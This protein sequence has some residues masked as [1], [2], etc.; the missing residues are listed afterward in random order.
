MPEIGRSAAQKGASLQ[1]AQLAI[2]QGQPVQCL[3]NP[4]EYTI[5]KS[6]TWSPQ[7]VAGQSLPPVQYGGGAPQELSFEILLDAEYSDHPIQ[8]DINQLLLAMEPDSRLTETVK[9]NSITRPPHVTFSWGATL[10]FTAG[11]KSLSVQFLRFGEEGTEEDG[12]PTRAQ[13]KLT[14]IQVA[15]SDSRS[16]RPLLPGQNPTTRA[17]AEHGSRTVREGDSL[18]SIA[19]EVYGDP[20]AWRA[21]AEAN[22][23]DDPLGLRRGSRLSIPRVRA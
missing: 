21:I 22:G 20:T 13:V 6:S 5:T 10:A 2:E 9:G 19:Y 18:Q 14:L 12:V 23:I 15:A 1:P 3:F 4:K 7:Q 17:I 8:Q 16:A 11:L